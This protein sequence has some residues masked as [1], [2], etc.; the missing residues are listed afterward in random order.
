MYKK[1][2]ITNDMLIAEF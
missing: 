1:M 2:H